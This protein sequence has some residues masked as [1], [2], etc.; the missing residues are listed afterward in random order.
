[1]ILL[2]LGLAF[3]AEPAIVEPGT[4][5]TATERSV[6]LSELD[7][8]ACWAAKRNVPEFEAALTKCEVGLDACSDRAVTALNQSAAMLD[9]SAAVFDIAL[10]RFGADDKLVSDCALRTMEQERRI[11]DLDVK[12][13]SARA[14]RNTAYA[15][16]GAV[17]LG[18]VAAIAL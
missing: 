18:A 8:R 3:A 6:L 10:D 2:L 7:F 9:K 4:K 1:M 17:V 11:T 15:V 12:L 5:V 14:Q 16:A 13:H